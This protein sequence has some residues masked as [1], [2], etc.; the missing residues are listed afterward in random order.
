MT[1]SGSS[2]GSADIERRGGLE[3]PQFPHLQDGLHSTQPKAGRNLNMSF[4]CH[5][6]YGIQSGRTQGRRE[7]WG[8]RCC[9][10]GQLERMRWLEIHEGHY[11]FITAH[12]I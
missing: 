7:G 4:F 6:C 12:H 2:T 8:S 5:L 1:E 3:L 10:L 11:D 9:Q